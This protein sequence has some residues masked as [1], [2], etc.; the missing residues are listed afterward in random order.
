MTPSDDFLDC[1]TIVLNRYRDLRRA[2]GHHSARK[3]LAE[4]RRRLPFPV[5]I[6]K[7]NDH[8]IA[9]LATG[10]AWTDFDTQTHHITVA[11]Q[12]RGPALEH[13]LAHEHFHLLYHLPTPDN[14]DEMVEH[15]A[16]QPDAAGLPRSMIRRKVL[17]TVQ[18]LKRACQDSLWE[19][20][21]ETFAGLVVTNSRK[22]SLT[23]SSL[24][25]LIALGAPDARR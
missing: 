25:I 13:T 22:R 1:D 18:P 19:R 24:P 21:A 7:V 6:D 14:I 3:V 17:S 9:G 8:T 12:L 15:F 11:R 16:S 4:M 20:Q 10:V 23:P 5:T 2:T